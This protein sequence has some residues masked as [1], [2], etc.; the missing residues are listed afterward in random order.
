MND[1]VNE[2][3]KFIDRNIDSHIEKLRDLVKQ[4]SVS[5]NSYG[6]KKCAG[7]IQD[8]MRELG[9]Q[10]V[11]LYA[12]DVN[13]IVFGEFRPS[14]P[15]NK[16]T[17]MLYGAY[18]SNP[19]EETD[20]SYPPYQAVSIEKPKIGTCLVG[21]GAN[22]KMKVSGIM[23]AIDSVARVHGDLP[24]NL[25]V[26][27]DGEEEMFSPHLSDFISANREWLNQADALYMPFSSQNAQ[28]VAR[29]QLGYKGILYLELEASGKIWGRGPSDHEIHSMHRPVVENPI[30]H[31]IN[32]LVSM[33]G[34][35]GNNVVIEGFSNEIEPRPKDFLK[36]M[37]NLAENFDLNAYTKG[38]GVR[39]LLSD[40]NTPLE[41]LEILFSTSQINID[42]IWGGYTG[43]GPEAVIPSNAKAK[44]EVRLIPNQKA[45][46]IYD[47]IR[48]H[49]IKHGFSDIKVQKLAAVDYCHTGIES[50]IAQ[51]LIRS[52]ELNNI[53]YQVWPSSLATIPISLFNQPPLE[54]PFSTGC[55]GFGGH[56][57]GPNEFAVIKGKYPISGLAEYEK[58]ISALIYEYSR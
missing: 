11:H 27:F 45:E 3:L 56:S 46:R 16:K 37:Q 5:V 19:V 31:L 26:V 40:I 38:L 24:L 23:N 47:L 33:T 21:R 29:V 14:N 41:A 44:I 35:D 52:Y 1:K 15:E 43:P 30:W 55:V 17:L 18:D 58:V 32:A 50:D 57:H 51:A 9:F 39:N 22:N 12:E 10:R 2:V 13:P 48:Q 34:K 49:L 42:G 4:P 20:W 6:T 7:M 36:V 8:W 28:G 25:L 53:K 54:L